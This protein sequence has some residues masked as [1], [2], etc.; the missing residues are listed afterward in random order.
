MEEKKNQLNQLLNDQEQA[1]KTKEE[2]VE[3]ELYTLI[4]A[5]IEGE[6]CIDRLGN[7]VYKT[8]GRSRATDRISQLLAKWE[9]EYSIS[10]EDL[11]AYFK[12]ILRERAQIQPDIEMEA[13]E[14]IHILDEIGIEKEIKGKSIK[15]EEKNK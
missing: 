7:L 2:L 10:Q 4:E 6:Y 1:R 8:G 13:N 15:G 11:K 14:L 5:S 12:N 9:K 3:M